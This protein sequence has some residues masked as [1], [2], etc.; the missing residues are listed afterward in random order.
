MLVD[1]FDYHLP[2]EL[3]AQIPIYPRDRCRLMVLNGFEIKHHLFKD[4]I[5][6][7]NPGDVLVLNNTRVRHA[8]LHGKKTTGGKIELLVLGEKKGF[9]RCLIKGKVREDTRIV[10]GEITGRIVHKNEGEYLVEFPVS[11]ERPCIG[12]P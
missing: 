6:Y 3:I 9:V 10:I 2:R 5:D 4:I 7:L 12:D 8:K 1:D 11:M